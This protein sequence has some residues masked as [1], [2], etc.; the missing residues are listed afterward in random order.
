ME[1]ECST[2]DELSDTIIRMTEF[3]TQG[4]SIAVF[5]TSQRKLETFIEKREQCFDAGPSKTAEKRR[6]DQGKKIGLTNSCAPDIQ[7]G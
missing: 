6:F 7:S 5:T 2:S 1:R 4:V 3:S